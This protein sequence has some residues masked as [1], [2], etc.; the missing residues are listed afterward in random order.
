MGFMHSKT[1]CTVIATDCGK[2]Q[3]SVKEKRTA[4]QEL[5]GFRSVLQADKERTR[6]KRGGLK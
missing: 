6:K 4:L 3:F 2:L 1:F 5:M